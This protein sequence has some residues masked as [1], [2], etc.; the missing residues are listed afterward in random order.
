M[1]ATDEAGYDPEE[2]NPDGA[3]YKRNN[4]EGQ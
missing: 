3:D 1:I 4:V 2:N